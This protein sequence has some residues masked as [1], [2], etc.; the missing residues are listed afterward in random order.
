[1]FEGLIGS[2]CDVVPQGAGGAAADGVGG[3]EGYWSTPTGQPL[4]IG[5]CELLPQ[6]SSSAE[7]LRR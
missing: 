2:I 6:K 3:S 4:R 7:A 1:M 5:E